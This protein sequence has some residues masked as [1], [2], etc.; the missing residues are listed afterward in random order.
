MKKE[1]NN[2]NKKRITLKLS[3]MTAFSSLFILSMLF[4]ILYIYYSNTSHILTISDELFQKT[5]DMVVEETTNFLEPASNVAKLTSKIFQSGILYDGKSSLDLK[6]ITPFYPDKLTKLEEYLLSVIREYPQLEY[7]SVGNE[8]GYYFWIERRKGGYFNIMHFDKTVEPLICMEKRVDF[9]NTVIEVKNKSKAFK[10]YDYRK[11]DWYIDA[12]KAGRFNMTDMYVFMSDSGQAGI[13]AAHTITEK[14]GKI[15]GVMTADMNL[16]IISDYLKNFKLGRNGKI[17]IINKKDEVIAYPGDISKILV[18]EKDGIRS[19]KIDE[20][21]FPWI[22][23]SLKFHKKHGN[24]KVVLNYD[25]KSYITSFVK[26]P[27]SFGKDWKIVLS[28]PEDDFISEIQKTN[29]VSLIF[30][31]VI[32]GLSLLV[33]SAISSSISRPVAVVAEGIKRISNFEHE[34]DFRVESRMREINLLASSFRDL[35]AGMVEFQKFV[36]RSVVKNLIQTDQKVEIGGKI[37]ELTIFFS[38]VKDFTNISEKMACD[39]LMNH[40]SQYLEA[41][42]GVILETDGTVDKYIGDAILAFWGAPV[43]NEKHAHCACKAAVL[44]QRKLDI[45]NKE[46]EGN[47]MPQFQTRIGLYT[48]TAIVGNVGSSFRVNY[49]VLGESSSFPERFES[50]NKIYGTRIIISDETYKRV[51]DDFIIRPLDHIEID[52]KE[53]SFTLYEVLELKGADVELEKMSESFTQAFEC[54]HERK[55]YEA[56]VIIS[57]LKSLWPQDQVIQIY[58]KRLA[59][60]K[61]LDGWNP[62]VRGL[63]SEDILSV[64]N[65]KNE[66]L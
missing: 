13:T 21:G 60:I 8:E 18:K 27:D 61:N 44:C 25:G 38:D 43:E 32:I 15:L 22:T 11:R 23:E 14:N 19:A 12:K 16:K 45:L 55:L 47:G 36:P 17:L 58:A 49:S 20:L 52:G 9:Y 46:W 10:N 51:K 26:F 65:N 2:N 3:I 39:D 57:E 42:T 56:E 5:T 1:L 29:N 6:K 28:A 24:K 63:R 40:F 41:M 7:I 64:G 62:N 34:D 48:G 4:V 30:S 59:A 35:K 31:V 53:K 66:I 37:D 33:I 54:Y 50:V